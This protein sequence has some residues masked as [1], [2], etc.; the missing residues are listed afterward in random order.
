MKRAGRHLRLDK[1]PRLPRKLRVRQFARLRGQ[2]GLLVGIDIGK[3][4]CEAA[5][6]GEPAVCE[7]GGGF[8]GWGGKIVKRGGFDGFGGLRGG[9]EMG[10]GVVGE[11]GMKEEVHVHVRE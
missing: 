10:W 6:D 5:G 11:M 3:T 2:H 1:L 9:E 7:E 4:V 8:G